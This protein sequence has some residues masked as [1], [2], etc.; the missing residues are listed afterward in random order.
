M[1]TSTTDLEV[2]ARQAQERAYA[3]YSGFRV[4]AALEAEDGTVYAGCNVE[5]SSYGVTLCAER[6]ALGTAVAAGRRSF[7]RLVLVADAPE[8]VAPCGACR[9]ALAEFAP[10]LEITAYGASGDEARWSLAELLPEAFR[11]SAR[12]GT[13][14]GQVGV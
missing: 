7:R 5:N 4:G 6:V 2:A 11:L 14:A 8:P 3:P 9:Q 1:A 13:S 12:A 10:G